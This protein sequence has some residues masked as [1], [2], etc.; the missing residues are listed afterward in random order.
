MSFFS[1]VDLSPPDLIFG[2]M[3]ELNADTNPK[4]VSLLVGAYRTEEGKSYVLPV[5]QQV[6]KAMANDETLGHEYLPIEGLHSFSSASA[7]LA[8]GKMDFFSLSIFQNI[9]FCLFSS[10]VF[11]E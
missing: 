7:K 10:M 11:R 9:F 8:L 1:D 5:V 2:I 3:D 4:K 6:E